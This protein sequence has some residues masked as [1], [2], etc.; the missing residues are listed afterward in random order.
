[1][2]SAGWERAGGWWQ[3]NTRPEIAPISFQ[4]GF[5]SGSSSACALTSVVPARSIAFSSHFNA[6]FGFPSWQ[7]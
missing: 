5:R 4:S 3:G 1:M 7:A 2:E 6:A